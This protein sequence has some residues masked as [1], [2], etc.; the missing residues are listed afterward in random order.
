MRPP[1]F[2]PNPNCGL[3]FPSAG[4]TL[5]ENATNATLSGNT[6]QCP[7]C[8]TTAPVLEGVFNIIGNSIEVLQSTGA[9]AAQL[10]RL[11]ELLREAERTRQTPEQVA[12]TVKRELPSLGELEKQ[13]LIPRTPEAF[14][15]FLGAAASVASL[16]VK[17]PSVTYVDR[18]VT[19]EQVIEKIYSQ[20]PATEHKQ[21]AQGATP[22]RGFRGYKTPASAK[23]HHHKKRPR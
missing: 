3:I 1:V 23:P 15:T 14:Y 16:F 2:C 6:E 12:G 10:A 7:R 11:A 5:G 4:F 22:Q 21:A 17:E 8:G 9:T 19:V 20:P 18:R 13:L